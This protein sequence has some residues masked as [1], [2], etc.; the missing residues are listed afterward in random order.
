MDISPTSLCDFLWR[1]SLMTTSKSEFNI[2]EIAR[3]YLEYCYD[4]H[5]H[6]L[7]VVNRGIEKT[8]KDWCLHFGGTPFGESNYK[9]L[10]RK[11]KEIELL[12]SAVN[13]NKK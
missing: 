4:V 9:F 13:K 6:L 11:F 3:E 1:S 10:S 12:N 7:L 5:P 8:A 2:D